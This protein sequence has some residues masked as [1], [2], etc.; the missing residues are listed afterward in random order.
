[1]R[2]SKH[3]TGEYRTPLDISGGR[4]DVT[5]GSRCWGGTDVYHVVLFLKMKFS[6]GQGA[7]RMNMMIDDEADEIND[8]VHDCGP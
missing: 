2:R 1:M 7:L 4:A 8:A 6:E 3:C 5:T